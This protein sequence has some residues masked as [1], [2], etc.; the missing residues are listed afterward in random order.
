MNY[1]ETSAATWATGLRD[2]NKPRRGSVVELWKVIRLLPR[3]CQTEKVEL[4]VG[5]V[6]LDEMAFAR[7]WADVQKPEVDGGVVVQDSSAS[8]PG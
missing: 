5:E 8:R 1:R 7:E 2:V 4:T 6:V 3:L